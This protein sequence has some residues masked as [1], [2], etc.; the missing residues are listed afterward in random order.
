MAALVG[1]VLLLALHSGFGFGL[2]LV[3][4]ALALRLRYRPP[5][6]AEAARFRTALAGAG[7]RMAD[8]RRMASQP[9]ARPTFAELKE[10]LVQAKR[11]YDDLPNERARRLERLRQN[12]R[13][14][15]VHEHLDGFQI[16]NA[17]IGGI[18]K[19]RIATLQSYGIETAADLDPSKLASV[20]GFGPARIAGLMAWR[21]LCAQ[22][23]RF[24]PSRDVASGDLATVERDILVRR[25]ALEGEIRRKVA[26][27]TA[28]AT[29]TRASHAA[30]ADQWTQHLATYQQAHADV[31]AARLR[32]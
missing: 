14:S 22:S 29:R 13:N 26:E 24:D 10:S 15:Q 19:G 31:L 7:E 11:T 17:K 18:G 12:L 20:Q 9:A 25:H 32:G 1:G 8:I 5:G 30:F 21:Q 6:G 3:L 16:R 23:F 28:A 4:G 2:C 27:L